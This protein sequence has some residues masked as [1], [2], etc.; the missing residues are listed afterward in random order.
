MGEHIRLTA[1][2]GHTLAAYRAT[3]ASEPVGGV[4]V[5]QEVFGLTAH[6]LSIV[7]RYAAEGLAAIAPAMFDR[8]EPDL[9]LDYSELERGLATMR[10]LEWPGTLADVQAAADAV[11][12]APVA[13]VGF[14]WGGTVAHVAASELPI[15]AAV[16]YYGSGVAR[17]LD[18]RPRCP[19]LYHFGERDASIPLDAVERV[20]QGNPGGTYYVYPDAGHGFDNRDRASFSPAAAASAFA[21]SV[22]FLRQHLAAVASPIARG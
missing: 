7:D 13:V 21:R 15:A 20:K 4:V 5:I 11:G 8:V 17:M 2:D 18:R 9:V 16:S 6:M 1:G 19:V 10:R 12:R 3:P 22:A 14:C